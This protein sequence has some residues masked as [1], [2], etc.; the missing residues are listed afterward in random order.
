[1]HIRGGELG[2]KGEIENLLYDFSLKP[3]K[4]IKQKII[5]KIKLKIIC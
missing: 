3:E 1:M 2:V 5:M 4:E